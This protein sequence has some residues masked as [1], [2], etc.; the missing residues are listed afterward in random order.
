MFWKFKKKMRKVYH[1]LLFCH[2]LFHFT[3]FFSLFCFLSVSDTPIVI[4]SGNLI[5][6]RNEETLAYADAHRH[7]AT[8]TINLY[9]TVGDPDT[10]RYWTV[11]PTKGENA[12]GIEFPCNSNIT[13]LNSRYQGYLS[14]SKFSFP[15]P[16]FAKVTRKN[17]P[18]SRWTV[19]CKADSMWKRFDQFQLKNNEDGCYLASTIRDAAAS[20]DL[21]AFPLIC[22]KQPTAN[23]YWTVQEGLFRVN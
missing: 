20:G 1:P 19:V 21:N 6:F 10:T 23:T 5:A 4:S 14:V 8:G 11:L 16:R 9:S 2:F 22:Q 15:L 7:P 12:T 17:R 18:S 3:M 13:L